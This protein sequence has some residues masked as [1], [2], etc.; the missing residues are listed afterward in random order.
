MQGGVSALSRASPA[1]SYRTS[2]QEPLAECI[3]IAHRLLERLVL[4]NCITA[5][6]R[7]QCVHHCFRKLKRRDHRELVVPM[8]SPV[9]APVFLALVHTIST[10][11]CR[12]VRAPP[13][14]PS[15]LPTASRMAG[16][17]NI[18]IIALCLFLS[19]GSLQKGS[20]A[21]A[22]FSGRAAS[23]RCAATRCATT[24]TKC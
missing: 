16:L 4:E 24:P 11:A 9:E 14:R 10:D 22:K 19:A 1:I 20:A 21:L 23:G 8:S 5:G 2:E 18:A 13:R 12:Y 17:A 15:R 7:K 3:Y 6:T